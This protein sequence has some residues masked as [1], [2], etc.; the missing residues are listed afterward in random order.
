MSWV[1][2]ICS[3]Y[4][5]RLSRDLQRQLEP[6][7]CSLFPGSHT[8]GLAA[9]YRKVC[10]IPRGI[11]LENAAGYIPLG[12]EKHGVNVRGVRSTV[13]VSRDCDNTE[14]MILGDVAAGYR[15][16]PRGIS[17]RGIP[18]YTRPLYKLTLNMCPKQDSQG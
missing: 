12:A 9:K 14:V 18:G 16:I 7:Q 2:K 8:P 13:R 6:L 11:L 10:L 4:P 3:G 15:S 5:Q 1:L 17:A